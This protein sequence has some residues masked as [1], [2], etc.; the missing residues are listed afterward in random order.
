MRV[1]TKASYV[2]YDDG[3]KYVYN[4]VSYIVYMMMALNVH[5]H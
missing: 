5:T 2:V 3:I 4:E 1:Y